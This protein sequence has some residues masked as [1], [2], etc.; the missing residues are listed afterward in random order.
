MITIICGEDVVSS[1]N[2]FRDMVKKYQEKNFAIQK[3]HAEQLGEIT[4][5]EAES[6]SLFGQKKIYIVEN[7]SK[8]AAKGG[9]FLT[10]FLSKIQHLKEKELIDWED[11]TAKRDLKFGA[12]GTI[13]EFKPQKN[14]FQLLES[15]YPSN[16]TVFL[17]LL[18]GISTAQN[19]GFVYIMLARHM[20]NVLLTK[21][22]AKSARLQA[23]QV[24]KL[25]KQ[26]VYW[27]KESLISFYDKLLSL[28]ISQKTGKSVYAL[29]SSLELLACYYL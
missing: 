18:T 16:L 20:R 5:E 23:W 17:S 11:G 26:A 13:K 2:Y 4:T 25:K 12:I 10:K 8:E 1:R 14:I 15:C 29:K 3:I 7:L 9:S 24:Q 21:L 28:D 27:E 19:I 6:P 22:G